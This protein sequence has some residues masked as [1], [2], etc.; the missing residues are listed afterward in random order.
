MRKT[1]QVLQIISLV[2]FIAACLATALNQAQAFYE[3]AQ[4]DRVA[5][6]EAALG[7]MEF[8]A[9]LVMVGDVAY[10]NRIMG[11]TERIV[12]LDKLREMYGDGK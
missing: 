9:R 6:T 7:C 5:A 8:E 11:G 1:R 10:C 12:A 2:C 4:A 3:R